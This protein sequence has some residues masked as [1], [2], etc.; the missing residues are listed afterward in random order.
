MWVDCRGVYCTFFVEHRS[1]VSRT[2]GQKFVRHIRSSLFCNNCVDTAQAYK[3]QQILVYV[4]AYK[5]F[6]ARSKAGPRR[7]TVFLSRTGLDQLSAVY[8]CTEPDENRRC[9]FHFSWLR[10]CGVETFLF[11][12]ILDLQS[13]GQ[14]DTWCLCFCLE[15]LWAS[16]VRLY[17]GGGEQ[18]WGQ[19]LMVFRDLLALEQATCSKEKQGQ[20][21]CLAGDQ[22]NTLVKH[23]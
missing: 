12:A 9:G 23:Q 7:S 4:A 22:W 16:G 8:D 20:G 19:L 5:V 11:V 3:L 15:R 6:V 21:L 1:I 17:R 10:A 14:T 13:G 18:Q 2:H